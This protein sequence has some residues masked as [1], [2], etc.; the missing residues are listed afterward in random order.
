MIGEKTISAI[1]DYQEKNDLDITGVATRSLI[2]SLLV[3]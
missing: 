3:D 2:H 1:K